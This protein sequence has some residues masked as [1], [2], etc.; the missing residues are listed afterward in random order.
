MSGI[1][2]TPG[3]SIRMSCGSYPYPKQIYCVNSVSDVSPFIKQ[4]NIASKPNVTLSCAC[5]T[6][7]LQTAV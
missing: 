1:G 5:R 7:I 6:E 4:V 3:V 2:P